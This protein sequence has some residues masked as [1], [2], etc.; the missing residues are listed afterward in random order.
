MFAPRGCGWGVFGLVLGLGGCWWIAGVV[1]DAIVLLLHMPR[2]L[3]F[4]LCEFGCCIGVC[5]IGAYAV[6]SVVHSLGNR[7]V[8]L[9]WLLLV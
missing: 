9:V 6:N 7:F 3:A 5:C 4:V 2:S 1:C 8:F